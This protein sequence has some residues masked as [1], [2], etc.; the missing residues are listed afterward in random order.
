MDTWQK[1]AAEL[2]GTFVLV[3]GGTTAILASGLRTLSTDCG[4]SRL[5]PRAPGRPLRL[6]RGLRRAL[7]PGGVAGDVPGRTAPERRARQILGR[8]VRRRDPRVAAAR[9][10]HQ[11]R[12]RR[13]YRRTRIDGT[14]RRSSWRSCSV[15]SSWPSSSRRAQRAVRR[16]R[17]PRNP[18]GPRRSPP[19]GDPFPLGEPG[20]ELRPRSDRRRV[21]RHLDLPDRAADRSADRGRGAQVV[22]GGV[23][24]PPTAPTAEVAGE[25]DTGPRRAHRRRRPR[26]RCAA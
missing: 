21:G 15:R 6:R 10:R 13:G 19:G 7:Q 20:A 4:R 16:E 25:P 22:H 9:A 3:F 17:A 1:Y 23:A 8:A 26:S 11:S 24:A 12:R 14:A 18:A 2:L 5:R